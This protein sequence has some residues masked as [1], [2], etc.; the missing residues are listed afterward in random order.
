MQR[1]A[2]TSS[3]NTWTRKYAAI[4]PLFDSVNQPVEPGLPPRQASSLPLMTPRLS[5]ITYTL[6]A[7]LP[8]LWT[9]Y[10]SGLLTRTQ[11]YD[12]PRPTA[13]SESIFR[14]PTT[15]TLLPPAALSFSTF[16]ISAHHTAAIW[17]YVAET[18]SSP[19]RSPRIT[20]FFSRF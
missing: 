10:C 19:L 18:P 6:S 7:R 4:V 2:D 12:T 8:A 15:A 14:Q 9:R 3:P 20:P 13:A 11:F 17:R 1:T 16:H 5:A